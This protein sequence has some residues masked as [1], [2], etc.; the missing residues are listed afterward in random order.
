MTDNEVNVVPA[1]N[2]T[3]SSGP[4]QGPGAVGPLAVSEINPRLFAAG[5]TLPWAVFAALALVAG[6]ATLLVEERLPVGAVK[7][8]SEHT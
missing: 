5:P 2:D 6:A 7:S 8:G 3:T 1:M 4:G